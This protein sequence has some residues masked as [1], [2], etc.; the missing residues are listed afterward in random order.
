VNIDAKDFTQ[1]KAIDEIIR[2]NETWNPAYIFVDKGYGQVQY[3][4]LRKWGH[5]H[6]GT[7]LERK[8][9]AIDSGSSMLTLDPI[10]KNPEKK[11][12][13]PFMVN[14]SVR[15]F[16]ENRILLNN[17][18]D[19]FTKQLRD[20]VV[21]KRSRD[22]RPVYSADN[23]HILDAFNLAM[24]A[25]TMKFTDLGRAV[26]LSEM[27]VAGP[28]GQPNSPQRDIASMQLKKQEPKPCNMGVKPRDIQRDERSFFQARTFWDN[29]RYST[30]RFNKPTKRASF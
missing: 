30:S 4:T 17:S 22:G 23:D 19:E 9:E 7:G 12:V 8:V 26:Y 24:L 2:L 13:K 15:Y 25:F 14:N 21:E 16:E 28:M 27:R 3:E 6:P 18:D 5:S 1:T 11:P 10:T 29:N 20:Y